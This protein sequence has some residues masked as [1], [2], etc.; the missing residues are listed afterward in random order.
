M[1]LLRSFSDAPAHNSALER[2]F[3]SEPPPA[4][5]RLLLYVNR[6][7]VIVGRNQAIEAEVD[8][9]YCRK[10]GIE[11]VRRISG[12]GAVYHDRGNINYAFIV[13]RGEEALPDTDFTKP[14]RD[15][16]RSFGIATT[17]GA[18]KELLV[19]GGMKIS[20]TAAHA[21]RERFLFHGTLL[22][23]T[24]LRCMSLALRNDPALR[25]KRIASVASPVVN[26]ADL[27]GD[28]ASTEDF[29]ARLLAFFERY[30]GVKTVP[31]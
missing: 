11:V 2:R 30:Y 23:R 1:Q 19:Q 27:T 3:L 20:G 4:P 31:C 16:L 13:A 6:P 26:L 10:Q 28:T 5:D 7:S 29:L 14:L 25:G 21:G 15:A 12:G 17:V 24:D 22:H 9:D 18:R 8:T